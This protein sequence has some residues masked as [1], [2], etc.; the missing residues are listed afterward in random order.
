MHVHVHVDPLSSMVCVGL[1]V[2]PLAGGSPY[3]YERHSVP[4]ATARRRSDQI[5]EEVHA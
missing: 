5:A 4:A 1:Q 2:L 3:D